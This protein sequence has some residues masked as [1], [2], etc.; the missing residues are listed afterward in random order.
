MSDELFLTPPGTADRD[1]DVIPFQP[2]RKLDGAVSRQRDQ[3]MRKYDIPT[4]RL[5]ARISGICEM[6][7]RGT[8]PI[9]DHTGE[10]LEVP[11]TRERIAALN[12]AKDSYHKMLAKVMPDLKQLVMTDSAGKERAFDF[13]V[14]LTE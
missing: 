12:S 11:L 5:L 13:K 4:E 14:Y 6:L 1:A 2:N 7:E 8:E 9:R 10:K 3:V